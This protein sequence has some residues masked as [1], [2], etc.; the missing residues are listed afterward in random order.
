MQIK[1]LIKQ[2]GVMLNPE[3]IGYQIDLTDADWKEAKRR[4]KASIVALHGTPYESYMKTHG[5]VEHAGEI[6]FEKVLKLSC[7]KSYDILD[8]GVYC[9]RFAIEGETISTHTRMLKASW[10]GIY[11]NANKFFFMVPELGILRNPNIFVFCGFDPSSLTAF[12]L[13]WA[14]KDLIEKLPL[15][16]SISFPAKKISVFNANT[17]TSLI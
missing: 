16:T 3:Q 5:P 9:P 2:P 7:R 17:I 10:N 6:A 11:I 14:G 1:E 13:G 15:D 12:V 4:S 8:D